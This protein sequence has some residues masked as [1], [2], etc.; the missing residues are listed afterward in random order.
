MYCILHEERDPVF[1]ANGIKGS[2]VYTVNY[3]DISAVVSDVA[4][5]EI[6]PGMDDVVVH[7]KVVEAARDS[8][9]VLPIRF[10][11]IFRNKEGTKKLLKTSYKDYK[12]KL[13]KLSGKDELGVKIVLEKGAMDKIESHVREES[14][15]VKKLGEESASAGK[16]TSYFLKLRLDDI[17][18][19]EAL[20]RVS[21]ISEE[22][23]AE[24]AK[25]AKESRLLKTELD[26]V[27]LNSVYLV[28]KAKAKEFRRRLETLRRKYEA[29]GFSF[30]QSG[31][32]APYSF[33]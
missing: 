11:V 30:H 23:H 24:L 31:P 7:N 22:I 10:G 26:Q 32:W 21:R 4:F 18:K 33:C 13:A 17:V 9:V 19:N 25:A 27:V 12:S 3:R 2:P 1:K 29:M 28:E 5:K 14:D 20:N 15:E 6:S 16:G 8:G